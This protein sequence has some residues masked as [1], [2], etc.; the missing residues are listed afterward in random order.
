MEI[1]DIIDAPGIGIIV[2]EENENDDLLVAMDGKN[3]HDDDA[4]YITENAYQENEDD[5]DDDGGENQQYVVEDEDL[6]DLY[7]CN[8]CGMNFT[9]IDDHIQRYHSNQDV[10]LDVAD[11]NEVTSM[12][13]TVKCEPPEYINDIEEDDG[14]LVG[15]DG[16]AP[17]IVFVNVDLDGKAAGRST[18][19]AKQ[20]KE[21]YMCPQCNQSF[22]TLRSL[23]SHILST[24]GT[25][26]Q[27]SANTS[28]SKQVVR[29]VV[30]KVKEKAAKE[31][32]SEE[33]ES[34]MNERPTEG[35]KCEQC[36][37]VFQSAKSLK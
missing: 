24:H 1:G 7:N 11:A 34:D 33:S 35:H 16:D 18:Q 6:E 37:T 23:S 10:I 28:G 17:H 12:S 5:D 31:K 32:H 4:V 15:E 9:S 26:S 25:K 19:N 27:T 13:S 2:H 20:S 14:M 29:K 3:L 8:V 22:G 30:R 21:A 36:N